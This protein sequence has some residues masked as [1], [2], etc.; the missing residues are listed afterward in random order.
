M[1]LTGAYNQVASLQ[2]GELSLAEAALLC[3]VPYPTLRVW[4]ERWHHR[5]VPGISRERAHARGGKRWR[6]DRSV[7]DRWLAQELPT[8]TRQRR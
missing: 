1:I 6:I 5:G 3:G 7:I 2:V 8:P 4:V